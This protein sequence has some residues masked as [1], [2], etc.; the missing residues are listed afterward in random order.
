MNSTVDPTVARNPISIYVPVPYSE[1]VFA[2]VEPYLTCPVLSRG[3]FQLQAIAPGSAS[4]MCVTTAYLF[5][6]IRPESKWDLADTSK[7]TTSVSQQKNR[8]K[9]TS[10]LQVRETCSKIVITDSIEVIISGDVAVLFLHTVECT[11][12]GL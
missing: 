10:W 8:H 7:V 1:C 6:D 3:Y 5:R 9:N 11:N 12:D 2:E 4:E